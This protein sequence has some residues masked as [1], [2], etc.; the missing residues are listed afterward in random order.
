MKEYVNS[1]V[2]ATIYIRKVTTFYTFIVITM[3]GIGRRLRKFSIFLQLHT[4]FY[5]NE[6]NE[7]IGL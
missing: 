2:Y 5:A 6:T 4:I 1:N 3:T 7:K